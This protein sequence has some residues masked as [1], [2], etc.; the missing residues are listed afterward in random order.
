M[1]HIALSSETDFAG[2]RDAARALVLDGVTPPDITWT[3]V[4]D[5]PELFANDSAQPRD[6]TGVT[7]NV[8]ARFVDLAPE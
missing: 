1:H 6:R 3:I 4:G 2:W 7:F 8:P 5:D